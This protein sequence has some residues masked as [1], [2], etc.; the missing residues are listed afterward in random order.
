M[1]HSSQVKRAKNGRK[2][3]AN[4]PVRRARELERVIAPIVIRQLAMLGNRIFLGLLPRFISRFRQFRTRSGWT[5]GGFAR[6]LAGADYPL[7]RSVLG[8]FTHQSP[9]NFIIRKER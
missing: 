3:R 4:F 5:L 8:T 9:E 1:V 2:S 6:I 7:L